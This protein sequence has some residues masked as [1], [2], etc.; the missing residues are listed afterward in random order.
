[1]NRLVAYASVAVSVL[2]AAS[3]FGRHSYLELTTHFRLQYA[4]TS[5]ALI[6]L[7]L[8]LRSWKHLPL[9]LC[10]AALNWAYILPYYL[11]PDRP[12]PGRSA[13]H[14]KL[15]LSNVMGSNRNY[16]ALTTASVMSAPTWQ[17]FRSLP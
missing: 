9:V 7:L 8:G 15:M 13:V 11:A 4:L 3:L 16:E 5:T 12:A 2:T 10:C 1:M 6:L 17:Y 14:L